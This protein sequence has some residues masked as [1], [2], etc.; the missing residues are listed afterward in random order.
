MV[1]RSV[2]SLLIWAA[3]ITHQRHLC[4]G[5]FSRYAAS[6][7]QKPAAKPK[8]PRH[9][10]GAGPA[11]SRGI[12][13]GEIDGAGGPNT[14]RAIAAFERD[15]KTTIAEALASAERTGDDHYTIT[16]EDDAMPRTPNIPEDMM[17]K[18]KL[19]R[20]DYS[21]MIEMLGERFHASPA[22]L[23]KLNPSARF[24]AGEAD[25]GSQHADRV[26]PSKQSRS[27]TSS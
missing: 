9:A 5:D 27:R 15:K 20:L 1:T 26:R 2:R 23:K 21:T 14:Q 16:A 19:K 10:A 12:L 6:A 18:A 11:R 17:E 22:L 25:H 4:R 7:Q 3:P 8:K 24:A 13:A